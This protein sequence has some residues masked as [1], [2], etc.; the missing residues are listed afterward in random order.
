LV[1]V[2]TLTST[3]LFEGEQI[4]TCEKLLKPKLIHKDIARWAECQMASDKTVF[5]NV[6]VFAVFLSWNQVAKLK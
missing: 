3:L 5:V 2:L 1:F 4:F 6:V